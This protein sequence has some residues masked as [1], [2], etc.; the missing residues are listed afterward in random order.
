VA[1]GSRRAMGIYLHHRHLN[2][3]HPIGFGLGCKIGENDIQN[4]LGGGYRLIYVMA[5]LDDPSVGFS[6]SNAVADPGPCAG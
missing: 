3:A 4:S 1:T 2:A 5:L 6:C